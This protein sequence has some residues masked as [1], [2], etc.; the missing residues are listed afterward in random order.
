MPY[1]M[2]F[3]PKALVRTFRR[4]WLLLWGQC[5][6]LKKSWISPMVITDPSKSLRSIARARDI[7]R[8]CE[9][10][11]S[12]MKTFGISHLKKRQFLSQTIKDKKKD[13]A[14]KLFYKLM[15]LSKPNVLWFFSDEKIFCLDQM[16]NLQK[17]LAYFVPT[18]CTDND[19]TL[20]SPSTLHNVWGGL[21]RLL[22]YAS[23]HIPT[24]TQHRSLHQVSGGIRAAL[25]RENCCWK[26]LLLA[27]GL[28]AMPT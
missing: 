18:K 7:E 14:V 3:T 4:V 8:D 28:C 19:E 22:W 21:S 2:A 24:W 20:W 9:S 27:T 10:F 12:C 26:T 5:R 15:H 16:M 11:L 23:N 25:D 17:P 6:G 13:S 1:W